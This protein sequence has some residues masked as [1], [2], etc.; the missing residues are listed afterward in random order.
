[1]WALW[2]LKPDVVHTGQATAV[3]EAR[4]SVLATPRPGAIRSMRSEAADAG[5]GSLDQ[6][7]R[8]PA[9]LPHT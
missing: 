8:K 4:A 6:P 2:V 3:L 7:T 1:M 9:N 5:G